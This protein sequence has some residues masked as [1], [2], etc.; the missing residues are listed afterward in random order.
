M[1]VLRIEPIKIEIKIG[2]VF[3]DPGLLMAE[4]VEALVPGLLQ[5]QLPVL[6]L[7]CGAAGS[8]ILPPKTVDVGGLR[9]LSLLHEGLAGGFGGDVAALGLV[10]LEL[11]LGLDSLLFDLVS[12]LLVGYCCFYL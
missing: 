7:G 4:V 2:V 11:P 12:H 10:I 1:I 5:A 9:F 8:L 6:E 3:I